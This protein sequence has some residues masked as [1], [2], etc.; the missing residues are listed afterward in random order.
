MKTLFNSLY[1]AI[2]FLVLC[3]IIFPLALTYVGNLCFPYQAQGSL[4]KD[5]GKI[6]GSKLIGQDLSNNP[7]YFQIN[8]YSSSGVDPEISLKNANDQALN[9]SVQTGIP[10]TTIQNIIRKSTISS[11]CI[12]FGNERMNVLMANI[13]IHQLLK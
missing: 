5:N 13:Q 11:Q 2:I 12:I 6:I 4:I 9:I 10:M 1:T 8:S 3:G 7:E